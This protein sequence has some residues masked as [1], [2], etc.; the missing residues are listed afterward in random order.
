MLYFLL[1]IDELISLKKENIGKSL[2]PKNNIKKDN[3]YIITIDNNCKMLINYDYI[4]N[5]F[6]VKEIKNIQEYKDKFKKQ[7][8]L[9]NDYLYLNYNFFI[10]YL[11]DKEINNIKNKEYI[12]DN[13]NNEVRNCIINTNDLF[14]KNLIKKTKK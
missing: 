14:L 2:S 4:L 5:L 3:L 13:V 7:F 11:F 1:T 9:I 8:F 12:I 10:S 6:N